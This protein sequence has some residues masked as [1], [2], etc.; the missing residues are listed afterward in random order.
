LIDAAISSIVEHGL[1]R[2]TVARVAKAAGLSPGI[3]TFYFKAKEALLLETLIYVESEFERVRRTALEQAGSDPARQLDAIIEATFDPIVCNPRFS[4]VWTAFSGEASSRES[5]QEVC[6]GRDVA[7]LDETTALFRAIAREGSYSGIAPDA[8]AAAFFH[9]ISSIPDPFDTEASYDIAGAK[10]TSRSFLASVFP[11]TFPLSERSPEEVS[12]SSAPAPTP[13]ASPIAN[14]ALPSWVYRDP[15]FFELEKEALFRRHWLLV[16]HVSEVPEPGD[17]MT[18]DAVDERALVI[19]G[20]D[21]IL[22]AFHNVC[23]HRASRV[24]RGAAGH[25]DQGM[26]CSLHGW[27]YG[28]DGRLKSIPSEEAFP[29]L[30]K[31]KIS[32]PEIELDEWLGF[33]FV[34]FAGSGARVSEIMRP[35]EEEARSYRFDELE[36][37]GTPWS[38]TVDV[39]WKCAV[40][41]GA[42][43]RDASI[44]QPGLGRLLGNGYRDVAFPNGTGRSIGLFQ[45]DPSA[46]WSERMYQ[47]LLPESEHLPAENRRAWVHYGLFPSLTFSAY[48]DK[49]NVCQLVPEGPRQVR[50]IGRSYARPDGRREM[51]AARYLSEKIDRRRREETLELCQSVDAGLRSTSYRGGPLSELEVRVRGFRDRLRELI[52]VAGRTD[53]P[54]PG[55]VAEVNERMRTERAVIHMLPTGSRQK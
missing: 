21:G 55:F 11:G 14:D 49:V 18:L 54:T 24:V 42:E 29:E 45:D 17:Y 30:D 37:L 12:G 2:T 16:G 1:S 7:H 26:I 28:F 34:R 40:E 47:K 36:P 6:S 15:E 3:V 53:A 27:Q 8:L 25:C 43:G 4:A 20:I 51:S 10:R 39:N 5:Y 22:R 9:L 50:F 44:A 19:R 48:P 32:L 38:K 13:A 41:N 33:V 46:V 52:P 35:F 31:A 23:V